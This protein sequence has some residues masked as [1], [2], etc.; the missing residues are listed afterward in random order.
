ML[1]HLTSRWVGSNRLGLRQFSSSLLHHEENRPEKFEVKLNNDNYSVTESDIEAMFDY[2]LEDVENLSD[3]WDDAMEVIKR[4][5][6]VFPPHK[7][8]ET[9]LANI[10]AAQPTAT[11]ASLVNESRTLQ[12]LVDLG[13]ELHRWDRYG[14]LGLAAKLDFMRDVAPTVEFLSDLG[15]QPNDIGKQLNLMT[16][17]ISRVSPTRS[18]GSYMK[19]SQWSEVSLWCGVGLTN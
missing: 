1:R 7:P 2:S 8:S 9:E 5:E 13:V 16:S 10:R 18:E 14:H 19:G 11:L 6:Q 15:L 4:S 3:H 17:P 12:R